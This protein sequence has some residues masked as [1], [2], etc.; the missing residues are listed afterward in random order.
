MS[1]V[2]DPQDA[3]GKVTRYFGRLSLAE[4]A[5]RAPLAIGERIHVRSRINIGIQGYTTDLV[6][7]VESMEIDHAVV[8]QAGPGDEVVIKVNDHVRGQE[9]VFREA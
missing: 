1:V 4:V 8:E 7:A 6:Q 9:L 5:L 2:H 3:I